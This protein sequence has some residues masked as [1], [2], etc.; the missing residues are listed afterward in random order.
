MSQ[1][2]IVF[3]ISR[4]VISNTQNG[5]AFLTPL[6]RTVY[7]HEIAGTGDAFLQMEA[8]GGFTPRP[9]ITAID[10]RVI[11]NGTVLGTFQFTRWIDHLN[12]IPTTRMIR[13][14]QG[15]LFQRFIPYIPNSLLVES[16]DPNDFF[17]VGPIVCHCSN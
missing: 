2:I 17:F 8:L 1:S 6:E 11:L 15:I 10:L 12:M 7:G 3:P 5:F 16:L 9:E 13:I 14:P 4:I